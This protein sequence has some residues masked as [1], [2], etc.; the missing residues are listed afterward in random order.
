MLPHIK[1][2]ATFFFFLE[3]KNLSCPTLKWEGKKAREMCR[4]GQGPHGFMRGISQIRRPK[5]RW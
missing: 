2:L 4:A 5:M 1:A 3:L